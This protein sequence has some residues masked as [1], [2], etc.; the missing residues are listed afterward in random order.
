MKRILP[1]L[2]CLVSTNVL[3]QGQPNI[4]FI[5]IDNLGYGEGG[6]Y[7]GGA[8]GSARPRTS[9]AAEPRR[10][11]ARTGRTPASWSCRRGASRSSRRRSERAVSWASRAPMPPASPGRQR[12]PRER[13]PCAARPT[14]KEL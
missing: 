9:S 2:L 8:S 1:L 14:R 6:V 7:G 11:A 12:G 3:A 10:A 4:V 13:R 5:L